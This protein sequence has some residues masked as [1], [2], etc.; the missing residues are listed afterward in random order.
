MNLNQ[1]ILIGRVVR[2]PEGKALPG[3]TTVSNLSLATSKVYK[4]K[5]GVKKEETEFHNLVAYGK[6]AEIIN[7]Y[8]KK[9]QLINIVGELKTRNWEKEGVKHYRTEI[10][11]NQ[12]QMGPSAGG[13]KTTTEKPKVDSSDENQYEGLDGPDQETVQQGDIPF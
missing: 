8:V 10:T 4:D 2:D 13:A 12:M 5:Q 7:Q 3:G 6:T 1:V 11:V 9:G